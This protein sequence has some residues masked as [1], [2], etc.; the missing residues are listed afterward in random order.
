MGY[1]P[2]VQYFLVSYSILFLYTSK[3][4]WVIYTPIYHICFMSDVFKSFSHTASNLMSWQETISLTASTVLMYMCIS[5]TPKVE[6]KTLKK[7]WVFYSCIKYA[8]PPPPLKN[9]NLQSGFCKVRFA[10]VGNVFRS[11]WFIMLTVHH[12]KIWNKLFSFALFIFTCNT[13]IQYAGNLNALIFNYLHEIIS[14][15]SY[16]N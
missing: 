7:L 13:L 11:S 3:Q 12:T 16:F 6:G 14:Q 5:P 10:C 8:T 9:K 4:Q 2:C 15:V 1:S